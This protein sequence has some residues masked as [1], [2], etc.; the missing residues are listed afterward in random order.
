MVRV[1]F[2]TGFFL[3]VLLGYSLGGLIIFIILQPIFHS[4]AWV[5]WGTFLLVTVVFVAMTK[6][7][8]L[9]LV[10]Y[11]DRAQFFSLLWKFE[12]KREW[13]DEIVVDT[14]GFIFK[15]KLEY[16]WIYRRAV[17][18][19]DGPWQGYR[20]IAFLNPKGLRYFLKIMKPITGDRI[21]WNK[22]SEK[23]RKLWWDAIYGTK[24]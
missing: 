18:I 2:N 16:E 24:V 4:P 14:G 21:D 20:V 3:L 17:K 8:P 1:Y 23:R 15:P 5:I 11:T 12:F 6:G 7:F 9:I 22:M 19:A 10:M 13:L